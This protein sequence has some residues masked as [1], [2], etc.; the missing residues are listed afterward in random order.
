MTTTEIEM[1]E[2]T[3]KGMV[4]LDINLVSMLK[5]Q[6]L[7]RELGREPRRE[8]GQELE[9]RGSSIQKETPNST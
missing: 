5:G 3:E 8:P 4:D 7:G 1:T 9:E 2:M 6:E